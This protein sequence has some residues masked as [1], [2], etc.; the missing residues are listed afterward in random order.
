MKNK[1]NNVEIKNRK[2]SYNYEF[3]EQE[4]AGISLMGSEVKS[5]K[6]GNAS[7]GESH[8]YIQGGECFINGM[9]IAEHKESGR[10][11]H[12]DPYRKRKLLLTKTQIRKWDKSLK[13]KG[14]TIATVK[15]FVNSKGLIK[16]KIALARGKKNYDKR[17]SIKNKDMQRD[18]D[19]DLKG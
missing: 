19:R 4:I 7:I 5:I 6:D 18:V 3:L 9:Y 10:N 1:K 17:E 13:L 2:A 8:C 14:N 12:N 15:L 11:G 16:I